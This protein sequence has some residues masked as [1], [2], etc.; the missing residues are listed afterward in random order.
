MSN[1][2]V[3][4]QNLDWNIGLWDTTNVTNMEQMFRYAGTFNIDISSWDTAKVTNMGF[5]FNG[6]SAFNQNIGGWNVSNVTSMRWMFLSCPVFNQDISSWDTGKVTNMSSMFSGATNF[7]QDIGSWNVSNVET[8]EGM[9]SSAKV[10]DQNLTN[11]NVSSVTTM[12][13]MFYQ[14]SVFNGDLSNWN[15]ISVTSMNY[16]FF[17]ATSFNQDI[18]IWDITSVESMANMFY[19]VTL[20]TSNY[21]NLLTSWGSK[22]VQNN[23]IFHGGK[24]KYFGTDAINGRANLETKGWTI[25]DSGLNT[26]P[27]IGGIVTIDIYDNATDTPFDQITIIDNQ[28][29]NVT[30][31][32]SF[33]KI[34]I[35]TF[36]DASL[37]STGFSD[38]GEGSYSL[39]LGTVADAQTA[40]RQLVFEPIENRVTIGVEETVTI[41]ISV[42][43]DTLTATDNLELKVTSVNNAPVID[44]SGFPTFIEIT[45]FDTENNGIELTGII[46]ITISDVD[47]MAKEGL[48]L[49]EVINGHSN[50]KW[51]YSIDS[52][53]S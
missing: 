9:F 50:G 31:T 7:N 18:S 16:M 51:Q 24:S 20:S 48:A 26:A 2:F 23:V 19:N 44:N 13:N 25:T 17:Y 35:G 49:I 36:T 3:N 28:N 43:D 30:V 4:I 1:M 27:E 45:R 22:S 12:A 37:T 52:G 15:P 41:T 8:M 46:G 33:D 38:N 47:L 42:S 11:W 29:D 14:C 32:I 6:A 21:S 39:E 53:T 5:M 40:L 34:S 10:F